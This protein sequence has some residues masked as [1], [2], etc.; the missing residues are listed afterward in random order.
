[1]SIN[2]NPSADREMNNWHHYQCRQSP[3]SERP[4]PE[5]PAG[6]RAPGRRWTARWC[7]SAAASRRAKPGGSR[8]AGSWSGAAYKRQNNPKV[9]SRILNR[10][11]KP[12][13][14]TT[15]P[16]GSALQFK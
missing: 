7:A 8:S 10:R 16:S 14:S 6:L 5:I 15:S 2:I 1:V 13:Q 4:P 9:S 3:S 11:H 12:E